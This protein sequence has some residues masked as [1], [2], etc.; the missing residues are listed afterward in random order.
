MRSRTA[1][2]ARLAEA[3]MAC[4][5]LISRH[6]IPAIFWTTLWSMLTLPPLADRLSAAGG[7]PASRLI[8]DGLAGAAGTFSV[9]W[10]ALF[11]L[12]GCG[13]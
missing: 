3:P 9:I 6:A 7:S 1:P 8:E 13:A 10:E 4:T 12:I 11:L 2:N 5:P